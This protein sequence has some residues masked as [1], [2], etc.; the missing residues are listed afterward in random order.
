MNRAILMFLALIVTLAQPVF[1]QDLIDDTD[2]YEFFRKDF[3]F[4][5]LQGMP[6]NILQATKNRDARSL[7][8]Y[9][10]LLFYTEHLT[11]RQHPKINGLSVLRE[12]TSIAWISQELDVLRAVKAVWASPIFGAND[13]N[14][15]Q[16]IEKFIQTIL[17][18]Q[19]PQ[20]NEGPALPPVETTVT[21]ADYDPQALLS[22]E[23][24]ARVDALQQIAESIFGVL[25]ESL[26]EV[27]DFEVQRDVVVAKLQKS[28]VTGA[29]FGE[30]EIRD[31]EVHIP[32][33]IEKKWI[34]ASIKQ[35]LKAQNKTMSYEEKSR[36]EN[37]IQSE[38]RSTGMGAI[39][40]K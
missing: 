19:T 26:T 6:V 5:I 34:L 23:E 18:K 3:D 10:A 1:S 27:E 11:Q 9:A 22:A 14:A 15:A 24:Y 17:Q 28:L 12:A 29:K 30:M 33:V 37:T 13:I 7:S 40:E 32:V 16:E 20:I 38:Y 2:V 31:G 36:L 4:V 39:I 25:I 21:T 35:T 8:M